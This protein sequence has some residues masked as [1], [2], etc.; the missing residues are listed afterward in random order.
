[1]FRGVIFG[2]LAF[3]AAFVGERQLRGVLADLKRY[4]RLRRMSGDSSFIHE[5]LDALFTLLRE[6]LSVRRGA[7][8][9]TLVSLQS[10]IR[11]Y[12]RMRSM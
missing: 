4:D 3:A 6:R 1:M 9:E 5:Q 12:L 11:R 8:L 7:G 10:D 2:S